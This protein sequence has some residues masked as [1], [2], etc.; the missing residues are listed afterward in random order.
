MG[1]EADEVL[2]PRESDVRVH[3]HAQDFR[4]VALPAVLHVLVRLHRH[5]PVHR[6]DDRENAHSGYIE[7][8]TNS[9]SATKVTRLNIL[10][11]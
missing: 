10:K 6:R 11:L 3:E 7:C 2:R 4:E 5:V 1:E 8:E 9:L